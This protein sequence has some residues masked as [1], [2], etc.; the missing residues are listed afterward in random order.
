LRER[1][2]QSELSARLNG[3]TPALVC[4][5][6]SSDHAG[7]EALPMVH[8]PKVERERE[9]ERAFN[10][11]GVKNKIPTPSMVMVLPPNML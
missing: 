3:G 2:N 6:I 4:G 9:R 10:Y 1:E 7:S 5:C 8:R 11:M